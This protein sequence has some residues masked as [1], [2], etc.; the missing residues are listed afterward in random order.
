MEEGNTRA[1]G[2]RL[3]R[4]FGSRN[5]GVLT[6]IQVERTKRTTMISCLNAPA[7]D[8][9]PEYTVSTTPLTQL[10]GGLVQRAEKQ[11][12]LPDFSVQ[13]KELRVNLNTG[14]CV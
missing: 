4:F 13:I 1:T 5:T 9:A 3:F 8:T 7:D 11:S 2:K 12:K 10:G 6:N 14:S